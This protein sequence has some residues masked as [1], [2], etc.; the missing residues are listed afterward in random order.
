MRFM[1]IM[2]RGN[3]WLECPLWHY[4][5]FEEAKLPAMATQLTPVI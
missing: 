2:E 5:V 3:R 1:N 4:C